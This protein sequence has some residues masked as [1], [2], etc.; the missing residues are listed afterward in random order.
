VTCGN[1]HARDSARIGQASEWH[2][3]D[4][5]PHHHDLMAQFSEVASRDR[6]RSHRSGT[7][8]RIAALK[9]P[10]HHEE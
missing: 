9:S 4:P 2:Q 10:G 5:N 3:S 7:R 1:N 8:P 6:R